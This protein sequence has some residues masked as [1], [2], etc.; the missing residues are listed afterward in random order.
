MRIKNTHN[1]VKI[2]VDANEILYK[3]ASVDFL[4]YRFFLKKKQNKTLLTDLRT[5]K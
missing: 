5:K 4:C 3:N 1:L 2:L